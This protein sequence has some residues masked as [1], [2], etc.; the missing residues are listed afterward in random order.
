MSAFGIGLMAIGVPFFINETVKAKLG[1][2]HSA[3]SIMY[4]V[5]HS[6]KLSQTE[7]G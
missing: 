6:L 7:R 1:A 5:Q 4:S 3:R 2:L